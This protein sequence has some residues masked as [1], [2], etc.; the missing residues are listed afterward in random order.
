MPDIGSHPGGARLGL[1]QRQGEGQQIP[2]EANHPG[3]R[4]GVLDYLGVLGHNFYLNRAVQI[5]KKDHFFT[6]Q[7]KILKYNMD[8]EFA[9]IFVTICSNK[10]LR[11]SEADNRL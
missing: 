5:F 8:S 4:E 10:F 3:S 2:A 11:S 1:G 9:K 7:K 6:F